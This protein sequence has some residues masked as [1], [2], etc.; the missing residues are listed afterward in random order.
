MSKKLTRKQALRRRRIFILCCSLSLAAVIGLLSFAGFKIAKTISGNKPS[1]GSGESGSQAS[2]ESGEPKKTASATVIN[3]GDILVHNPVLAGALD[4]STGQYDFSSFFPHTQSYFKKADLAVINLEVTLG[5]TQSGAYKGYPAFNTPDSLIDTLSAAGIGMC[6]TANNHSYDTGLYGMTRTVQVLK[7]KGMPYIGT[8]E[9]ED[10]PSFTVK[11]VNGVKIGMTCYTYENKCDTAGR[12]SLNGN[13]L[14]PEANAIINS[15]AYERIDE[16][17]SEA[18][19]VIAQMRGQGADAIVFYVH[20]GE[21]YQL[22]PNQWQK[23]IA[24]KLCD[25]G[26]D[27]IVGGHPHVLQPVELLHASGSERTTVCLYS[28][29]NSISNQRIEEMTGVC[30]SG[31]TEDGVLF[32]YTFDKYS[33]GSV[34]LSAVDAVPTWVN[35][36]GSRYSAKYTM[37]PLEKSSDGAKFDIT[38]AAASSA[39]KSYERTRAMLEQGLT[40][41]QTALGCGVRVWE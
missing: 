23:T 40:A 21:E 17:Y 20:W 8:R 14:K 3:T 2:S 19:N 38:A 29:G 1:S 34:V 35:K 5:G 25:L 30:T 6:L 9:T 16:F 26:V 4:S 13:I 28:M 32:S 37:I 7:E 27:V 10:E 15:F 36:V 11:N 39:Q 31:H 12:K 22:S 41:C 24:Q 18:E 33:D